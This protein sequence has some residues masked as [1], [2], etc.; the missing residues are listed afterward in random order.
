MSGQ[1]VVWYQ[2]EAHRT[3]SLGFTG[4]P[5]RVAVSA[6]APSL[7]A[8]Q[9]TETHRRLARLV[10]SVFPGTRIQVDGVWRPI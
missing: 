4:N 9:V 1:N 10:A 2:R 7:R 3:V 6:E 8:E 5:G